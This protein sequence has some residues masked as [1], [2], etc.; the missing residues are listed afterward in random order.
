M[1]VRSDN[2]VAVRPSTFSSA[3]TKGTEDTAVTPSF[4]PKE[5]SVIQSHST[6]GQ[7]QRYLRSLP[8]NWKNTLRTF[9]QVVRHGSANCIEAALTA[10]AIME[11]HGYPPLLLDV[12][13][14]DGLDHV[15]FLYQSGGRWGTIAKSRDI[16][17]HGRKP[18]FRSVRDLVFSY[19]DPYVDYTGRVIGYG[20]TNLNAL[21]ESDWRLSDRNVW[22]IEKQ[23]IAMPH[24]RLKTSNR[25]YK[26]TFGRFLAF[27]KR[28]PDKPYPYSDPGGQWL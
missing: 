21:T 2:A 19:V 16:G 25:R 11:Q 18:V 28:H 22:I 23:L 9:R 7:V 27:K 10:A 15:L 17:L 8:Y 3:N 6:P 24:T 12:M 5:R 26:Q 14:K 13:S 20:T 4:T 1:G